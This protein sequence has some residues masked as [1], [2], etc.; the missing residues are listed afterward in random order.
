MPVYVLTSAATFSGG[1]ELAYDVQALKL[2]K[3]VGEVTGGGANPTGPVPLPDGLIAAIPFG[4]SENP[5]TKT[6]WEGRGVQPD[7]P[8]PAADALKTALQRLGQPPVANVAAASQQQVFTLRATPLPGTEAALKA[9]I[10]GLASGSPDYAAMSPELAEVTRQ[11][12]PQLHGLMSRL[13]E[14]RSLKFVGPAQGGDVYDVAF[15]NGALRMA[16]MLGPDGT[17]TG[18]MI[19]PG[20]P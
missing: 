19:A 18:S 8:V 6:N 1:E 2:G 13:G 14:I 4:R 20:A 11:Q 7:I 3:I 5:V 10:A 16:I 9:S 17:I 12:L 15:A